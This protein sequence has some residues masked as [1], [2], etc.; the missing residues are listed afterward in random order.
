MTRSRR[1]RA[2]PRALGAAL[3]S[4]FLLGG[5]AGGPGEADVVTGPVTYNG[6]PVPDGVLSLRASTGAAASG[7][8][9]AGHFTVTGP[10]AAG[11]YQ[12]F[13]TPPPPEPQPPGKAVAKAA[14]SPLP[15]RFRDPLTSGVVV[16]L[17]AGKNET[18]VEFKD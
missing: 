6:K 17:K 12:A 11:D 9:A 14:P 1:P 16:T 10:L 7:K 2:R 5:C 3:L 15:P 8:I 13:V 4:L 18:P